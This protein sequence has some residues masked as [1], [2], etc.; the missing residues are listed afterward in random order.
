MSQSGIPVE[1]FMHLKPA[2]ADE[3]AVLHN[4]PLYKRF[5]NCINKIYNVAITSAK[6]SYPYLREYITDVASDRNFQ[7]A[8]VTIFMQ[9]YAFNLLTSQASGENT[10]AS[11]VTRA[12]ISQASHKRSRV[13]LSESASRNDTPAPA[14]R[15]TVDVVEAARPDTL[16]DAL[17]KKEMKAIF[18]YEGSDPILDVVSIDWRW[19]NNDRQF[20]QYYDHFTKEWEHTSRRLTGVIYRGARYRPPYDLIRGLH[21][22]KIGFRNDGETFKLNDPSM[23]M[24]KGDTPIDQVLESQSGKPGCFGTQQ[25]IGS[26][27]KPPPQPTTGMSG[28]FGIHTMSEVKAV[29][30]PAQVTAA[31]MRS[32]QTSSSPQQT[33]SESS[34]ITGGGAVTQSLG[35]SPST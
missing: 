25:F 15:P 5:Y 34:Q 12:L 17:I 32:L 3:D 20:G 22:S 33:T 18:V 24:D 4:D 9:R 23:R 7:I 11:E 10:F 31:G 13:M 19:W 28:S 16:L 21:T 29:A 27:P 35:F 2:S 6:K 14:L 8:M 1:A 26:Q 30:Q